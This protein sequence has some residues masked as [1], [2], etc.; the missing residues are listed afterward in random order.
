V[1]YEGARALGKPAAPSYA[2]GVGTVVTIVGL[3]LLLPRF[4]FVGAA[5]ASTL[6]YGTSLFFILLI[7]N[8]G[9]GMGLRRF[10][11]ATSGEL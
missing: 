2:E 6:A 11:L 9:L 10:L 7:F 8:R 5:I 1:L 3:Y 4:G